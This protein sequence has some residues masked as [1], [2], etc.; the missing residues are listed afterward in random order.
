M[1]A[2]TKE[3]ARPHIYRAKIPKK[4]SLIEFQ[5]FIFERDAVGENELSKWQG[6]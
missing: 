2:A 6:V 5:E 4:A 1:N 3:S